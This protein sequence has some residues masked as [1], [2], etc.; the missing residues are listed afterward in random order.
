[1]SRA[2]SFVAAGFGG[3]LVEFDGARGGGFLLF[4]TSPR[5]FFKS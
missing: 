5:R 4:R 1:M 3:P 2:R